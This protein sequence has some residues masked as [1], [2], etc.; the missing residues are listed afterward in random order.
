LAAASLFLRIISAKPPPP[1]PPPLEGADA[2]AD[3]ADLSRGGL[4]V[5]GFPAAAFTRK[6]PATP[7]ASAARKQQIRYPAFKMK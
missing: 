6:Y 5:R 4:M 3:V 1:P 2:G 7:Y